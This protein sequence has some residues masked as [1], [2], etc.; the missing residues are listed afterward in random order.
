[1]LHGL[2]FMLTFTVFG[3]LFG[4]LANRVSRRAP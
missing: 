2:A 1:M 4:A 3:L